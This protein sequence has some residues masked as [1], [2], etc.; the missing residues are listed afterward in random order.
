MKPGIVYL[1]GAGPGDP[2]L[3]TVKGREC[4]RRAEVVIY[5]Y[6]ANPAFLR[7]SPDAEYLYVGKK[8]GS[9]HRSQEEINLLL[10]GKAREGKTV[11]RL[12]GGDP[13]IFGRG[14]EE[15]LCLRR[16]GIPF[17]VVPG[18]TAGF[19]AAAYAG[20]PLTHRDY[21]TSLAL[22]T[23]HEDPAKK[24]SSLDWEKLAGA[25]GTL[26]FYMG[27]A[28]ISLIARELMAHGRS[29]DTP[30]AIVRWATT[31]RQRTLTA[32]LGDVVEKALRA[33]I[34]PPAVIIVGAV[35]G[36]REE[37]RWFD[38]RP[39]FG[40]RIL[41][42]RAGDQAGELTA[43]LEAQGAEVIEAP[44][45]VL[46]A[47]ESYGELDRAIAE[48]DT[49]DWLILTSANGVHAF[50]R[51]LAELGRDA[52][53]LG[54]CRICVV[55]PKTAAH[56]CAYGLRADLV[57]AEYKGEGVVAALAETALQ[58]KKILFPKADRAREVIP[59]ELA[60]RG[61]RVVAPVA[62]RNVVPAALPDAALAALAEGEI[63]CVAFTASSTV[64]NLALLLG[65]DLAA[66]IKGVAV[67][68]IGPITSKTCL[69]H[70]LDIAVE[71]VEYTLEALVEGIVEYFSQKE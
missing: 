33:R 45:I 16:A 8:G 13:F 58:D 61:A 71:P 48:L 28:N 11:A 55:G 49:F 10:V 53:A 63:D 52:R 26:V 20:I 70:G 59:T 14:G 17:E 39:L 64:D 43:L 15:A 42:T 29:A 32:T 18:V 46:V 54:R 4:L 68:S 47:P 7:E 19:A 12:K 27:M 38:N 51:R 30:V 5:D 25:I 24:M 44:T 60:K 35:V 69:K 21:T 66:R 57:A 23:G 36:L 22:I 67:A 56:L 40:K 6:L 65:E 34:K 50:F 62:Y 3:I 41:N 9:H 31:A 37:L 2:G 1:I